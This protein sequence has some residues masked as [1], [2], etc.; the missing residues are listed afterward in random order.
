[1]YPA[2]FFQISATVPAISKSMAVLAYRA[3][4]E[5]CAFAGQGAP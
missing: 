5:L 2:P 3:M 4:N 1:M